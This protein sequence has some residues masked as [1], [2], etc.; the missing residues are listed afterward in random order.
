MKK[1][2][3]AYPVWFCDIWGVI[4]NGYKPFAQTVDALTRHRSNGG[5]VILVSNSPRSKTGIIPQ[6]D[7]IGVERAAYDDVVTSGD[8]TQDLMRAEPTGRLFHLGPARDMSIFH[9]VQVERVPLDQAGAV[10]CTGLVHDDRETPADYRQ[11]L[12]DIR[13]RN[14]TFICANP[15]K[16][17]R[18]GDSLLYCA[19][20]LA[21]DYQKLG[22]KVL[23]AGKP[24]APIYDL[25][26]GKAIAAGR[27]ISVTTPILAI[28]DGPE[29]DI[30]GAAN[31]G[32][33]CLYVSGGVRGHVG[34]LD[35]E[36]QA[37]KRLVP[38][39]DILAALPELRWA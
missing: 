6:L 3:A 9:N 18:K 7:Q 4:H 13:A 20:A 30:L 29:T 19:G 21:E 22:G 10:I 39:A 32:Y 25:A 28:G 37:I 24:Y 34:D 11:I 14:L 8:V 27:G 2:S 16:V 15:D 35:A 1:Y 33:A 36:L 23:M 5:V 31:Q 12:A 26:Q 38:K 17:V